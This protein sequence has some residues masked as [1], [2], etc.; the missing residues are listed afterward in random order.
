MAELTVTASDITA[1]LEKHLA[2]FR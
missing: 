2:G 1:A